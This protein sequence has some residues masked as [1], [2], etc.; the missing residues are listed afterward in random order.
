MYKKNILLVLIAALFFASCNNYSKAESGLRFKFL[1]RSEKQNLPNLGQYLQ[2][3]YSIEN[4]D[5]SVVHSIFGKTPDRI[6]LRISLA[7]FSTDIE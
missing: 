2:C 3:Y 4:S 5:D 6:V 1:K 7:G